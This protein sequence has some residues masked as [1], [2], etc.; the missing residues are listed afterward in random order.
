[1]NTAD[2]NSERRRF[3]R[4]LFDSPARIADK[5]I[6]FITTLVDVSL[7]GALLIRPDD[8]MTE[9]GGIVSLTILLDDKETRIR[10]QTT[11]AHKEDDT[12]GLQC[13]SIDMES[14]AHLRR[15]VELNLGDASLLD[16]DLESLG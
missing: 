14:I 7:N 3:Q 8:W 4:V 9:K 1:M 15:L 12:L 6:E 11:V 5:G 16:R 13:E 2:Q 10:M